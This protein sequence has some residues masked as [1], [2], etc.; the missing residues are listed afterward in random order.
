M[1][2]PMEWDYVSE[3]RPPTGL[4]LIPYVIYEHE[5][6]WLMTSTGEISRLVQG[7]L[8]QA[9]VIILSSS[10]SPPWKSEISHLVANREDLGEGNDGFCLRNISFILVEF[11]TCRKI[12]R[13]GAFGFTSLPK[14]GVLRISIA[15][16]SPSPLQC[17]NPR[18]LGPTVCTVTP[19]NFGPNSMY[20]NYYTTKTTKRN[21]ND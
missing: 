11:L 13:R 16:I 7:A 10:Y 3:L 18:T 2:M 8:G 15:L 19:A 14:E 5:E 12:L 21:I 9:L 17:L 20:T 6:P 1:I 4:L